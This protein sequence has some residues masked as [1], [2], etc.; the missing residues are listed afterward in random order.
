MTDAQKRVLQLQAQQSETREKLNGL[1]GKETRTEAEETEMRELTDAAQKLEPEL[2]AALAVAAAE[3]PETVTQDGVDP[4]TRERIKLRDGCFVTNYFKR[5][6]LEGREA[7]LNSELGFDR[8]DIPLD[9]WEKD[10]PAETREDRAVTG[11]PGTVG[12]NLA[13]IRPYVFEPSI[14]AYFGIQMPAVPSGTYA[15]PTITTALTTG[16][17]TKG[18][19]QAATAAAF[20]IAQA[21]PKSVS[22]R[23]EFLIE[24]I[25]AAGTNL[26]QALRENLSMALSAELDNQIINGDGSAPNLAGLFNKLADPSADTTTLTFDHGLAKLADLIDGLWATETMQVRQMVGVDS[27][28]LAAKSVSVPATG[29]KGELTLADYLRAHSG[30]FR[31]NKRMPA[32][33]GTK[34]QGLAHRAGMPGIA[35]AII[36]TWGR[37]AIDDPFSNSA[38]GQRNITAHAIVGDL[39]LTHPAA[40]AQVEFK[41]S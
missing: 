20:T 38:K 19:D 17:R 7:E 10:R 39:I 12:L 11:A 24:D 41:V 37:I 32:K 21:T 23:L 1:L 2:R 36:P 6:N 5:G 40:Y 27:Y 34:Q 31:T 16:A 3:E 25:A 18:A 28:V 30:G 9:L 13:N 35:S 4:E 8:N 33:S 29:G 22:A 15:V 14:A 26:E